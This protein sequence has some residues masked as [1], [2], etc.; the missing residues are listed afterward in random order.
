MDD[1]RWKT[2]TKTAADKE[3]WKYNFVGGSDK[4]TLMV[5]VIAAESDG[6]RTEVGISRGG[7]V[8]ERD[9][10][11]TVWAKT[12]EEAVKTA[13][14]LARQYKIKWRPAHYSTDKSHK[15]GTPPPE[16]EE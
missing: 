11:R 5:Q 4:V 15:P 9:S 13:K 10:I 12:F 14:K 3:R 16:D 7:K 1:L 2:N 8:I 6:W